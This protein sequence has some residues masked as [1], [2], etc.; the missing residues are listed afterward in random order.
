MLT[1][2]RSPRRVRVGL[3]ALVAVPVA[4]LATPAYAAD[5]SIDHVEPQDGTFQVLYSLPGAGAAAPDLDSVAVTLDDVALPATAEPAGEAEA[6]ERT[7]I[8]A[9]DVSSSMRRDNRFA[10]AQEAAKAFLGAAPDDLEVGIVTFASDVEVA[11]APTL[12]REAS[13]AVVDGLTLSNQ[14]RLYDGVLE[15]VAASG[16][17]GSRSVLV[18][19]DG[20][21]TSATPI[22][23]VTTAIEDANCSQ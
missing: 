2:P 3:A 8:L 10:E 18:L 22:D 17:D 16:Q 21:D 11:Q 23:R 4:L 14:T 13:T 5:G 12:D 7:T 9:I 15:A 20:R 6:V 1:L 19:S